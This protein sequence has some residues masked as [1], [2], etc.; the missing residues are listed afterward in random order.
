MT[1]A[2]QYKTETAQQGVELRVRY[3]SVYLQSWQTC[4]A[5]CVPARELAAW[6]PSQRKRIAMRIEENEVKTRF[7]RDLRGE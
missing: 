5:R 7:E 1:F 2:V 4:L 6:T 3:W